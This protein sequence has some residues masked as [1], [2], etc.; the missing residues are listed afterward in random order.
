MKGWAGVRRASLVLGLLTVALVASS[1]CSQPFEAASV[2]TDGGAGGGNCIPTSCD[3]LGANCGVAPN[4][5]GETVECGTCPPGEVCGGGG[6]NKCG[7]GICTPT[8]CDALGANC[9]VVSDGCGA[10]L[11]CGNCPAPQTCGAEGEPNQ[12]GCNRLDCQPGMCGKASDG[13]GGFRECGSCPTGQVC[14]GGGPN[15]CGVKPCLPTTCAAEGAN[16]GSIADGCGGTLEC[17][18][19]DGFETCGG[20]GTA[21]VCG[22]KPITCAP[23]ECGLKSDGCGG[24]AVCP[25]QCATGYI[26]NLNTHQCEGCVAG[27]C[28]SE[29]K[30]VIFQPC[31]GTNNVTLYCPCQTGNCDLQTGTCK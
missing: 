30:C 1:A 23:G 21:K 17:G 6:Q 18:T 14:G 7:P 13:C 25:F 2:D 4:G 20:G 24:T 16:C 10:T 12:C 29:P 28:S 15:Q 9:G 19:C 31:N 26:C 8:T 5:C 27:F 11:N 3:K 22:C